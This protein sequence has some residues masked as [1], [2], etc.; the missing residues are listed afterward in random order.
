MNIVGISEKEEMHQTTQNSTRILLNKKS[1]EYQKKLSMEKFENIEK[2]FQFLQDNKR[3]V[4][5][6][7]R[8]NLEEDLKTIDDPDTKRI[9]ELMLSYK[10]D[11]KQ[12]FL[13]SNET[14]THITSVSPENMIN[15]KIAKSKNRAN[16]YETERGDWVFASS[17]PIDGHNAYLARKSQ[18]GMILITDNIY[19]YGGD[20]IEVTQ[21][22]QGKNHVMLK[23]PNYVYR[24]NPKNF[25]PVV[26][27]RKDRNGKH[28]FEFSEEWVSEEELDIS[29]PEHISDIEIISDITSIAQNYQILCDIN[30]TQEAW[31]IRSCRTREEGLQKLRESIEKGNLRY[32]NGEADINPT[33][34]TNRILSP[35][36]VK[37]LA[38]ETAVQMEKENANIAINELCNTKENKRE[39]QKQHVG[40]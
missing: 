30:M 5:L 27:L 14:L 4:Y 28:F 1:E 15:G 11:I 25:E 32:I 22:E 39:E 6:G 34:K 21:D 13:N 35:N 3:R 8:V 2:A 7:E 29:N 23:E 36:I 12:I 19:V 31:K 33:L 26:T 37:S 10:Q 24:I 17:E 16:N 9:L 20:N 38:N 40:K 18:T